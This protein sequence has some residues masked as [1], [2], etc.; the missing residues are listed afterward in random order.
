MNKSAPASA[1]VTPL[2]AGKLFTGAGT[3]SPSPL[4]SHSHGRGSTFLRS[5]SIISAAAARSSSLS[6]RHRH[7]SYIAPIISTVVVSIVVVSLRGG[8]RVEAEEGED[9]GST[10]G[11]LVCLGAHGT[12]TVQAQASV[13]TWENHCVRALCEANDAL[14]TGRVCVGGRCRLR[15]V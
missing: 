5:A 2:L 7:R 12:G 4:P 13:A 3:P 9:G 15:R 8:G 14:P 1:P 6:P 10:H 11:T